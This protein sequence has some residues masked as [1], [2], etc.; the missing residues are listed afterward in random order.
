MTIP[1]EVLQQRLDAK[2]QAVEAARRAVEAATKRLETA[3]L[4]LRDAE[5][6]LREWE[7]IA[8]LIHKN[9]ELPPQQPAGATAR[10]A[11]AGEPTVRRRGLS[12]N[13][14][15]VMT[16]IVRAYP[17]DVSLKDVESFCAQAGIKAN[18]DTIRGQ[19]HLYKTRRWLESP[20][21]G[22]YRATALGA[23]AAD[24]ELPTGQDNPSENETAAD[25]QSAA[26]LTIF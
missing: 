26:D 11:S 2:R 12:E 23:S 3:E 4:A 9:A 22:R 20:N 24:T 8:S 13:W 7:E 15:M 19:M 5:T 1:L 18:A 17:N 6:A 14:K 16:E 10:S 25:S 21:P